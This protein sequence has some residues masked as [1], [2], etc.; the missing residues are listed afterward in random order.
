MF[1]HVVCEMN[2]NYYLKLS[3][4]LV[5]QRYAD[6][7][8]LCQ[9]ID[10]YCLNEKDLSSDPSDCP[11][12]SYFHLVNYL[13]NAVSPYTMESFKAHKSLDAFRFF[14]AGWVQ[15]IWL[16]KIESISST[17]VIGKV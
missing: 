15:Q 8:Q 4:P 16:K 3:D 13:I 11:S 14:E 10:P 9:G 6:K 12:V 2:R 17:I 1:N 7:I 5:R